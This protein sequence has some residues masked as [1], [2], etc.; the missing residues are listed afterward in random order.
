MKKQ[1]KQ[2]I[3][4]SDLRICFE[5]KEDLSIGG[6]SVCYLSIGY[7]L[8]KQVDGCAHKILRSF[9]TRKSP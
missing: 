3:N 1:K 9:S 7:G 6:E 8:K 2:R 4:L 5:R